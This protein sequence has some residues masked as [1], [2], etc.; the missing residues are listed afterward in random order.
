[1][2]FIKK[3]LKFLGYTLAI[4]LLLIIIFCVYVYR[5][6]N[7]SPPEVAD[8]SALS[9]QKKHVE[10]SLYTIGDNWIRKNKYGLYEMYVSGKPFERG[11]KNGK[12]SQQ[13]ITDQEEAFT[14]QIKQMIPSA[15]YLKFLKYVIGFMNKNLPD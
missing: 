1:M 5:V 12:L 14:Q 11:V 9:L 2:R 15:G 7:F 8:T 4:F 10:G 6:S 3:V 13:L